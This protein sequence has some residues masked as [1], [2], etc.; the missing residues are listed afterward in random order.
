M[1]SQAA[2]DPKGND[3]PV[4]E[5]WFNEDAITYIFSAAEMATKYQVTS[6]SQV[7]D[8]Y[9][10]HLPDKQVKFTRTSSGLYVFKP[11]IKK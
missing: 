1:Q 9:I 7:Q 8:A 4:G 3:L 2:H 10:V 11:P 5:A 6:D